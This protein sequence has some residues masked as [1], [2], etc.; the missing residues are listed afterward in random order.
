M[1][2]LIE[3]IG[4]STHLENLK[5][6][7]SRLS[8]REQMIFLL[9]C[10]GGGV[11]L[12]F[13]IYSILLASNVSLASN[14]SNNRKNMQTIADLGA[15]YRTL[16]QKI[17]DMDRMISQTPPNFQLATE[18]ESLA[19]QNQIKIESIKDRPGKPHQFYI[20][21]QALVS[22]DQVQIRQ[23]IDFL[24][25]IENSGKSMRISTLQIK[26]NFKDP[27]LLNVNFIVSTFQHQS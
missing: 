9:S 2:N 5:N 18:L 3:L 8:D 1:K 14:I 6:Y 22:L 27:K 4:L 24:F 16:N 11:F 17:D 19:S 21:S 23:L 13:L 26:P 10:M 12:L 7:Y 25:A 20:E 15:K